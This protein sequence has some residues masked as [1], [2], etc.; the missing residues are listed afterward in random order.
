M[1]RVTLQPTKMESLHPRKGVDP[2]PVHLF[3]FEL[4]LRATPAT[5]CGH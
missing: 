5:E 2:D 3:V 1:D 4:T